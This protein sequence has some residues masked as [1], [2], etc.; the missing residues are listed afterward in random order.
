MEEIWKPIKGYEGVYEISNLGKV[1]RLSA[2][3]NSRN[4]SLRNEREKILKKAINKFGYEYVCLTINGNQ[5]KKKVHR[6]VAEAFIDNPQNKP[7][8]NHINGIKS[9]N[10]S[11]NLEWCNN[12]ENMKHA[13]KIGLCEKTRQKMSDRA[14]KRGNK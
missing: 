3:V 5:Q 10:K 13:F 6:L 2:K 1:K 11:E 12:Q 9:D 4:G 14:K 8:V 7:Q